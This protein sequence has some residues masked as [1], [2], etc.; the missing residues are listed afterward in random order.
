MSVSIQSTHTPSLRTA[1][2]QAGLSEARSANP[3]DHTSR[4]LEQSV[5]QYPPPKPGT[6]TVS[7]WAAARVSAVASSSAKAT[8]LEARPCRRRDA[9]RLRVSPACPWFAMVTSTARKSLGSHSA[10][11]APSRAKVACE[12]RSTDERNT[13][14]LSRAFVTAKAW[15]RLNRLASS[16]NPLSVSMPTRASGTPRLMGSSRASEAH[17]RKSTANHTVCGPSEP[18]PMRS[19]W[20]PLQCSSEPLAMR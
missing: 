14:D 5:P 11:R 10:E 3:D 7:T 16:G 4:T 17:P 15:S 13:G 8:K 18:S 1:R 9:A 6:G 2:T 19:S 12:A 20:P